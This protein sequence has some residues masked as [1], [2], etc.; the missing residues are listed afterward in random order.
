MGQDSVEP[1]LMYPDKHVIL[2]SLTSNPGSQDFQIQSDNE[3]N[4]FERVIQKSQ[5]WSYSEKLWYVVGAT[6]SFHLKQIRQLV[7][8]SYLLV[9][10]IGAQGGHLSEVVEYG[11][12]EQCGLIV[13]ASRSII[14]SSKGVDFA[15]AAAKRARSLQFEMEGFLKKYEL[16]E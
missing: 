12:N 11:F 14:Y 5:N 3:K 10:G 4:L 6:Q 7:P 1:F 2:L 9:P 8:H 15:H 16:I 13:N